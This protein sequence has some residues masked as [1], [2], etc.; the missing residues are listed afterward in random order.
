MTKSIQGTFAGT[1]R[2]D[3]EYQHPLQ[4]RLDLVLTPFTINA[5]KQGIP[6]TEADNFITTALNQPI[7]IRLNAKGRKGHALAVPI[8]T[9]VSAEKA[10]ING[11]SAIVGK[12]IVW[13]DEFPEVDAALR[14]ADEVHTSWEVYSGKQVAEE[15]NTWL[16]EITFAATTIVDEPAYQGK[17]PILAIAEVLHKENDQMEEQIAQLEARVAEL[18]KEK[19]LAVAAKDEELRLL[20][21]QVDSYKAEEEK[22]RVAELKE[23][24]IAALQ[25]LGYSAEKID[26]RIDYYMSLDDESFNSLVEDVREIKKEVAEK[27]G[28]KK[29]K[30]VLVPEPKHTSETRLSPAE[31]AAAIKKTNLLKK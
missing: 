31:L 5:N 14:E 29:E 12:A 30:K 23:T 17:T 11:E 20:Q 22:K 8:G 18:E 19:E 24:R 1:L 21:A 15:A 16:H 9:I 13:K 7:K 6:E 4:T 10:I 2:V 26:S 28:D 25:D 3:A 27:I